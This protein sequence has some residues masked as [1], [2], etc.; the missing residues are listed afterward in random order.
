MSLD[1]T[2]LYEH[3]QEDLSEAKVV[4]QEYSGADKE[5]AAEISRGG[6]G[7]PDEEKAG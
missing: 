3:V 7:W 5:A 4:G 1:W 2:N 6:E